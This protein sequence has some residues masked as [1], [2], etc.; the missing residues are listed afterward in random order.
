VRVL[1]LTRLLPGPVCTLHLADMGADVIKVEDT[2]AGD[3]ARA[4]GTAPGQVS[5]FYRMVNRNKRSLALDLKSSPGRGALLR[6]A[7]SADVLIEGFRPGIVDKL[8]IGYAAIG[9]LN[10]CIVYCAITGYG[11]TG[12][13]CDR[14]G[15]DIN[16]L[17]YAGVLDQTGGDD[18]PPALCN[19]QIA[20]LL[21]GALNAAMGILAALFD[22]K[23]SGQGRYVDISMTDGA[24]AH[25][26]FALHALSAHGR[27]AARGRDLLS[28]G[29]PCYGVYAT[30]DGRYLAVGALEE[31]F[32]QALCA[33]LQ[34]PEL[35]AKQFATGVAA[36]EVK[37]ELAA[38]FASKPQAYW[39]ERLAGVD[40][41]VTPVLSLE[42]SIADPQIRARDM[43]LTAPDGTRQYAPPLK[44]S[45]HDFAIARE[46]PAQGQHSREVLQECG[47]SDD[48]IAQLAA[49]GTI[50]TN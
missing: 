38:I 19:L 46:A 14:A 7:R 32:W 33:A 10:P 5:A 8:G 40:C 35:V 4:L 42:E 3:Y 28:G 49:S 21:G 15:H 26:I 36:L 43:V 24:L 1:D 13:Y 34:R 29:V 2:G 50:R 39:V 23:R 27:V 31:K 25:N 30:Q 16:Y 45:N 18:T 44:L 6:L 12:P 17:G 41:C 22:A 20:D 37:R 11:Q 47:F 9:A 48:E